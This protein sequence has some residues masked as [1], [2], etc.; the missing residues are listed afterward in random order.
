VSNGAKQSIINVMYALLDEGDEII[1][2]TP[3]W[4]SYPEMAKMTGASIVYINTTV[5]A[6]FKIT[7]EQLSNA[8]TSKTKAII[9][10]SPSNP[11]GA[12][13]SKEELAG[14]VE[15][16]KNHDNIFIISDEIYELINF[17]QEHYSIASFPEVFERTIVI[18]G[19]SKAFAMTGWRIGYMAA[20]E[21]IVNAC[22]KIQSQFTS[23]ASCIAQ[24]ATIVALNSP[25]EPT[26]QMRAAYKERMDAVYS[27]LSTIKGLK[28]NKPDGAFYFFPDV[29]NFFNKTTPKGKLI[30]NANDLAMYLLEDA[31]VTLV[32]GDG[33]GAPD[34][35]RMSFAASK[36]ELIE[37][38]NRIVKA[39]NDLI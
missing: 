37:A 10:S 15:V 12:M 39:L 1:I 30:Q 35:I 33:F 27:I 14:L 26:Y 23:A 34:C 5:E 19:V 31:Y 20:H 24:R 36:E 38:S 13:Y 18:N 28:I 9:F 3:Y 8:I 32:S 25:Y 22:D 6:N 17:T 29:S 2:P 21:K 4:V 7:P 11:T 16:L